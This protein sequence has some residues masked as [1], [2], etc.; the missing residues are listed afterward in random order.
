MLFESLGRSEIQWLHMINNNLF[1]Q[2]DVSF[3]NVL[4]KL[5]KFVRLDLKKMF[6][7]NSV[8]L[9]RLS[10]SYLWTL[11]KKRQTL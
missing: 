10:T 5:S 8:G 1:Q 7:K 11:I 2:Y 3:A 4:F 6:N 9:T